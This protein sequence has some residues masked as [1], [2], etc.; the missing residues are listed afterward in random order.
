MKHPANKHHS[1]AQAYLKRSGYADGGAV[2]E[3]SGIKGS[4]ANVKINR[5]RDTGRTTDQRGSQTEE[6]P[7]IDSAMKG[8]SKDQKQTR[9]VTREKGRTK[10]EYSRGGVAKGKR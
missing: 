2:E 5:D 4:L 10:I 1:K 6:F 3:E 9:K 8:A 7:N